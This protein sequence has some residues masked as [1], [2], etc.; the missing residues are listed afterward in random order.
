MLTLEKGQMHMDSHFCPIRAPARQDLI[1]RL[2]R[3]AEEVNRAGLRAEAAMPAL[4]AR[5][6]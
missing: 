4:L 3:L 2:I 5:G 1:G 6:Q